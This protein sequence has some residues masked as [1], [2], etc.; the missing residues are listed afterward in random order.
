[1]M[2]CKCG[3]KAEV[4]HEEKDGVRVPK[5]MDCHLEITK[6]IIPKLG[7]SSDF[8]GRIGLTPRQAAKL[9]N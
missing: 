1:M 6:G 7:W 9:G 4:W 8:G 3:D 5:C 2:K